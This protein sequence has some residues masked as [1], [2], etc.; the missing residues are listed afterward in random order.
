MDLRSLIFNVDFSGNAS[1]V[2]AMDR[3]T[4]ELKSS[5]I[6]ATNE[7]ESMGSALDKSNNVSNIKN[8]ED[9]VNNLDKTSSKAKGKLVALQKTFSTVG[10]ELTKKVTAPIV[11][12]GTASIHTVMKFDDSMS[13]VQ[14]LS[15]ATTDQFKDMRDMA[16]DLGA[17]TAHSASSASDAMGILASAGYKTNQILAVTPQ[18]LSL[19]SAGGL[20]LAS[21]ASILTGTIAQFQLKAEDAV[22]VSDALAKAQASS[23]ASVD[24]LGE[25]LVY[26]GGSANTM[27]MDIQQTSAFLGLFADANIAGGMAGTTFTAMFKDLT[28]KVKK[29]NVQIGKTKVAVYDA[30]GAMRDMGSIMS[31]V[32]SATKGMTDSQKNAALQ[33][34]FTGQSMKGVDAFLAQGAERYRELEK[35]IYDSEGASAQMASEMEDNIG[36]AFRGMSSAIEGFMIELGDVFKDDVVKVAE[37]VGDLASK[38]GEFD[39][40]TKRTIVT[41]LALVAGLGP[42]LVGIAGLI[43]LYLKLAPAFAIMKA[44]FLLVAGSI[45]LPVV[46]IGALIGA[47]VLLWKNWDTVST[48]AKDMGNKIVEDWKNTVE[49]TKQAWKDWTGAIGDAIGKVKDWWS[50]LGKLFSKPVAGN[51]NVT[52]STNS[53]KKGAKPTIDGSHANGLDSVPFDGYIAEVHK[54]EEVLTANDPR[55]QNNNKKMPSSGINVS[56][57][58]SINI[59]VGAGSSEEDKLS[60]EQRFKEV[61]RKLFD[62]F[63]SEL[64][65]QIS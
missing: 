16:K 65:L 52:Q 46:A 44:G 30:S 33:T 48:K 11:A 53:G 43:I 25:S 54:K 40:E 34:V 27:G 62:E 14:A 55:N 8:M 63:F 39:D 35:A 13:K 47:G 5:A 19:A 4:D 36:G 24:A 20:D 2:I 18:V 58:P 49:L 57:N 37:G 10:K 7:M 31:D 38:F 3:A 41:V 59:T 28:G 61:S 6:D 26:A 60:L 15:G 64:E 9:Q 32:E 12:L 21:T 22:I 42:L 50:G 56:Y 1:P 29:G 23:K 17:T 51:I 45:S